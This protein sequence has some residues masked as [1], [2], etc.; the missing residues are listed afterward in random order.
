MGLK[1]SHHKR[2][3]KALSC[4]LFDSR[5]RGRF[6]VLE[7]AVKI[8]NAVLQSTEIKAT[9]QSLEKAFKGAKDKNYIMID[10]LKTSLMF[11]PA[12]SWL[13]AASGRRSVRC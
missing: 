7:S 4:A 3:Y 10:H 6:M 5:F 8:C 13:F 1:Y 12:P 9:K 2:L 11:P